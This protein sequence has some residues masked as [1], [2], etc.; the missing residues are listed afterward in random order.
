MRTSKTATH[1]RIIKKFARQIFAPD[2]LEPPL[3]HGVSDHLLKER[4]EPRMVRVR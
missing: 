2:A 4:E 1:Y 3:V